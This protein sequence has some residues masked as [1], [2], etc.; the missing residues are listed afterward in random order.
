MQK[1]ENRDRPPKRWEGQ[2]VYGSDR[3]AEASGN[4]SKWRG[5]WNQVHAGAGTSALR[6]ENSRTG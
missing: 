1:G 6:N 3:R 5:G 2:E 4:I